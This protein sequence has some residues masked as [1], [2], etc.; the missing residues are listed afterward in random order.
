VL[1]LLLLPSRQG[2]T[3]SLRTRPCSAPCALAASVLLI[4]RRLPP[5]PRFGFSAPPASRDNH[6]VIP[7]R[8]TTCFA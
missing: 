8:K 6:P 7:A 3:P 2:G 1:A 4:C 5:A